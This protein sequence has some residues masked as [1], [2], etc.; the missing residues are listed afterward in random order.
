[1]T[2]SSQPMARVQ[3]LGTGNAFSPA[4]RMNALVLIDEK[5]LVD[6]PPTLMPQLRQENISPA[7]IEHLLITHW[8]ADHVFGF[9]FLMLDRH[10]VSD[11]SQERNLTVHLRPEGRKLLESIT[12][13]GF[14]GSIDKGTLSVIK[15]NE[16]EITDLEN[17]DWKFERFKVCHTPETD[18]HGY[19]LTHSSGFVF[20]HTGDSGP[21][22]EIEARAS[23]AD[24]I[25][26]EM[27]V[28]NF[29]KSPHHHT[30]NDI[31]ALAE[32][33][34]NSKI[35]V[36]HNFASSESEATGFPK[37]KLA[38][39]I[40]QLEDGDEMI[41]SENCEIKFVKKTS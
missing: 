17:S 40:I 23:R 39:S 32:R 9:P 2:A 11:P 6:A 25:L 14:P 20:L 7:K 24:V 3:F 36:T 28:P 13:L 10:H 22:E 34:P 18:P 27:G 37:P 35:L 1:M 21:C 41:I 4:G 5:I 38:N 15:W 33:F 30:P 8:H 19:E 12:E 29:V 26:V 16:N 31:A